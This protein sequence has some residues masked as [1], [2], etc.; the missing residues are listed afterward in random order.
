MQKKEIAMLNSK[1][2]LGLV[3]SVFMLFVSAP[4]WAAGSHQGKVVEAG[5]GKLT[6]TD[7]AGANQHTHP[8][9]ADA[10]ITCEG[11]TCDLA[12]LQP[13]DVI[14]VTLDQKDGEM[15]VTEIEKTAGGMGG[16]Q[17]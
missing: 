13:G 12:S 14:T 11:Q 7:M 1:V 6:M 16:P 2:M 9:A 8:V 4:L 5:D 3:L 15:V 17:G 10:K